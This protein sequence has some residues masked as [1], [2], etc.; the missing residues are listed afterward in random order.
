[1]E[2]TPQIKNNSAKS[3]DAS[4]AN[5]FQQAFVVDNKFARTPISDC[6][7]KN[8]NP[9]S[10][11]GRATELGNILLNL[12]KFLKK[13]EGLIAKTKCKKF[14]PEGKTKSID[15][16]ITHKIVTDP[17]MRKDQE[18]YRLLTPNGNELGEMK[19][20]YT[21]KNNAKYGTKVDE[22]LVDGYLYL[23]DMRTNGELAANVP[24]SDREY[25]GLGTILE[26]MAVKRSI[27][28]GL[29]GRV[30]LESAWN[31]HGFHYKN[32]FRVSEEQPKVLD[33][34]KIENEIEI[35]IEKAK[36][37]GNIPNTDHIGSI[38]MYLPK[39]NVQSMLQKGEAIELL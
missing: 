14:T 26:K 10:F 4:A 24:K 13:D 32:Y 18:F 11:Q 38:F 1:M 23:A 8:N 2:I 5:K 6:F 35:A 17:F 9:V 27:E 12:Q 22:P 31:S 30:K 16:F 29:E 21:I 33:K 7:C 3:F 39:E 25:S 20:F 37:I 36:N 19:V 34:Q 28:K 15:V